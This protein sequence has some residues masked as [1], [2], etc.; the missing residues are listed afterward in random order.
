MYSKYR[1]GGTFSS[2]TLGS[3]VNH[4][5]VVVSSGGR[6]SIDGVTYEGTNVIMND[7]GVFID[8]VEVQPTDGAAKHYKTT[9]IVIHGNVTGGVQTTSGDVI[10]NQGSITGPV[11]TM[12]GDVALENGGDVRGDVTT[13]SGDVKCRNVAGAIRTTSGKITTNKVKQSAKAKKRKE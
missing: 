6:I 10:V 4:G 1:M 9:S 5:S 11:A 8:G 3:G 7:D 12:S 13:M 2:V